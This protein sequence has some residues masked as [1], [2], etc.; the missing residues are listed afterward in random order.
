MTGQGEK[1]PALGSHLELHRVLVRSL[2]KLAAH[3]GLTVLEVA[4]RCVLSGQTPTHPAYS[5]EVVTAHQRLENEL[6]RG[7]LLKVNA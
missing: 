7:P 2:E 4:A 5:R 6:T 3:E 1:S